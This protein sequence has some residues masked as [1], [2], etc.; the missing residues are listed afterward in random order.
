MHRITEQQGDAGHCDAVPAQGGSRPAA[1]G[2]AAA[3]TLAVPVCLA[4]VAGAA[5]AG[6]DG[7]ATDSFATL[8]TRLAPQL[9]YGLQSA[10]VLMA[11]V[12]GLLIWPVSYTHL[13]LPTIYSV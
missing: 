9:A 2:A 10:L 5:V 13:T 3:L 12:L 1:F 6:A 8:W 7:V 4:Q 11:F